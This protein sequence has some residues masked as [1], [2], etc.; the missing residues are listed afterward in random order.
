MVGT[1]ICDI[2]IIKCDILSI[3]DTICPYPH[4]QKKKKMWVLWNYQYMISLNLIVFKKDNIVCATLV[5]AAI[6]LYL[7][8]EDK[9]H[10]LKNYI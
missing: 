8:E 1:I 4:T 3:R 10:H 5:N 9:L 6:C 7:I 2:D